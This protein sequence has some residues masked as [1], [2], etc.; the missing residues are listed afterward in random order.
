MNAY[1]HGKRMQ[2]V[3]QFK[4]CSSALPIV[5]RRHGLQRTARADSVCTH[6]GPG[7]LADELHVVHEC[8]AMPPLRQR[9]SG[10][11]TPDTNT[12]RSVFSPRDHMQIFKFVLDCLDLLE[13]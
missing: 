11:F 7:S 3:L 5:T 12:M 1:L 4:L 10:P 13:V 2:R 9:Y 6:R 8:P